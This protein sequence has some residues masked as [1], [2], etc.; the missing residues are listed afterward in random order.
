MKE[1]IVQIN[2]PKDIADKLKKRA[3]ESG[4]N[5][6]EDYINFILRQVLTK[7]EAKDTSKEDEEIIK[8]KLKGL[9]YL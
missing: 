5:K 1:N 7:V 4:F 8:Q 3:I 6:L 9:G 2:I